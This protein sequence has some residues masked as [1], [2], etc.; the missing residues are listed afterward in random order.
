M[1]FLNGPNMSIEFSIE[2]KQSI[3]KVYVVP[4]QVLEETKRNE[5]KK[6]RKKKIILSS[7]EEERVLIYRRHKLFRSPDFFFS[8]S[9]NLLHS[10]LTMATENHADKNVVFRKLKAKS[11]NKVKLSP[12]FLGF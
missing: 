11:E 3:I 5:T 1:G 4:L 10:S 9:V 8:R 2:N 7:F 6:T 12:N